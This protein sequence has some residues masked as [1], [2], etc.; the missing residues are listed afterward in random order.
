MTPA[1]TELIEKTAIKPID[2]PSEIL[3]AIHDLIIDPK[4]HSSDELQKRKAAINAAM[5]GSPAAEAAV[6]GWIQDILRETDLI[7]EMPARPETGEAAQAAFDFLFGLDVLGPLYR[8][9]GVEEIRVNRFDR[10]FYQQGG[11]NRRAPG[12]RFSDE[13]ALENLLR[14]L[15]LH[16]GRSISRSEPVV[17]SQ[18][19]DGARVTATVPPFS[20]HATLILRKHGT[21]ELSEETLIAAGTVNRPLIRLLAAL[22]AGRAN[23]LI[24]GATDTGK[25]SLLRFLVRY[26]NPRLR[27]VTLETRFELNLADHYPDRDI[28]ALQEVDGRIDMQTAFRHILRY[29]PNVIIVGEARGG[30]A[31]EM[32]KACL[33]GH[34]GTMGTVHTSGVEEAIRGLARMIVIEGRKQVPLDVQEL[35]VAE[36]F[37]V[38][39]QMRADP[40]RTGRRMVEQ[41]SEVMIQDGKIMFRDLCRWAP[42]PDDWWIGDWEFP[43]QPSPRLQEKLW[44]SGV[45][46]PAIGATN[47]KG[48]RGD[49]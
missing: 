12:L 18:R 33:R 6:V 48:E 13:A 27:I 15:I 24:S 49:A 29:T 44:R 11:V 22:V 9:P 7:S 4:V 26:F 42:S 38:V 1:T 35:E 40:E 20:K 21:I 2:M 10:I 47:E 30:E 46:W 25:T 34:D 14:R 8:A 39:V 43:N 32:V 16:D 3:R 17:E 37:D 5:A 28:V 36:A 31:D 19:E 45:L 23:I 41:V